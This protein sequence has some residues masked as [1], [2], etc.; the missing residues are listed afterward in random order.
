MRDS[1]VLLRISKRFTHSINLVRFLPRPTPYSA[2]GSGAGEWVGCWVLILRRS[3]FGGHSA[4]TS[5]VATWLWWSWK[6]GPWVGSLLGWSDLQPGCAA[7]G[8]FASR[9]AWGDLPT[10]AFALDRG[11]GSLA[12]AFAYEV[13]D[14]SS[15]FFWAASWPFALS[16]GSD[17]L[18]LGT[19]VEASSNGYR[20]LALFS[21]NNSW[22]KRPFVWFVSVDRFAGSSLFVR[23]CHH[24]ACDVSWVAALR[25][26]PRQSGCTALLLECKSR[27]I[28][29]GSAF[30]CGARGW[31]IAHSV[32]RSSRQLQTSWLA[33]RGI[34]GLAISMAVVGR[35]GGA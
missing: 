5:G 26:F 25:L 15:C 12:R 13:T 21:R 3:L 22:F 29:H 17:A 27:T 6:G 2:R 33:A 34:G 20:P 8:V 10:W 23:S 11:W 24:I 14:L 31:A 28:G 4:I 7:S 30:A 16:S 35:R 9:C 1:F 32:Y 19:F 18:G